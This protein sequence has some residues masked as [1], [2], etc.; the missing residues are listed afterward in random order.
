MRK[1]RIAVVMFCFLVVFNAPAR[2]D[3]SLPVSASNAPTLSLNANAANVA[4]QVAGESPYL[5]PELLGALAAGGYALYRGRHR[6]II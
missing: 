4:A 6:R 1:Y 5:R 2:A 3:G